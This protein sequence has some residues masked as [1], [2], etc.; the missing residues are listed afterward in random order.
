M[1]DFLQLNTE[2]LP[3]SDGRVAG[4]ATRIGIN[5]I[6][7]FFNNDQQSSDHRMYILAQ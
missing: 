6:A 5:L 4:G 2:T 3:I 7:D 1:D